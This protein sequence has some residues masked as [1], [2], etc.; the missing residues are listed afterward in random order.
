MHERVHRLRR[1]LEDVDQALVRAHLE[2]L[3]RLLVD[4]RRPVDAEPVDLRGE[5]HRTADERARAL[6]RI[7]DALG[8]LIEHAVI[9]WLEA[10]AGLRDIRREFATPLTNDCTWLRSK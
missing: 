10:D 1:C 5:R 6:R 8:R 2:V 4:V 7:D 3:A 9:V